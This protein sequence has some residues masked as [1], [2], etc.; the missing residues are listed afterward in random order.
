M[1]VL[2]MRTVVFLCVIS[3][4]ICTVFIARL[5][6][7]NRSRFE[8][9]GYWAANCVMQTVGLGL[10]TARGALPDWV[11]IVLANTLVLAGAVLAYN[12]LERFFRK[13]GP[14]WHNYLLLALGSAALAYF[15]L[16]RA[17]LSSRVLVMSVILL[18]FF[19][20]CLWLLRFRADPVLRPLA[21]G[22][23]AV[24][25]G[26]CLVSIVRIVDYVFGPALTGDFFEPNILQALVMVTYQILFI[27]LTYSLVVM[28]NQRLV[29]EIATEQAKFSSAF[30][31]APYA[32]TLTRLADGV[33]IDTNRQFEEITGY[34]RAD[35]IGQSTITLH[36]WEREEDRA[37]VAQA[38]AE[39][40][41]VVARE[42]NFRTK[43]GERVVGLL[44]AEIVIVDGAD[45]V[46]SCI[47]DITVRKHEEVVLHEREAQLETQMAAA[48]A[49][50]R[51]GRIAA[52]NL[53]EDA[54]TAKNQA[55]SAMARAQAGEQR[56][57]LALRAAN[58]GV[59]DLNVQ[60][61]EAVVSAE[62]ALMLGYDPATFHE[63]NAAWLA[64]LHP[65]DFEQAAKAY[66]D[67]LAGITSEYRVEF[68]QKTQAGDWKWI[69]SLGRLVEYDST[70]QPL[71]M[72]G[73]HTD[74]TERKRN[75]ADLQLQARRSDAL[76][77]LP[78]RAETMDESTFMQ[79]G[80]E[81]A[82][83]LTGSTV[84]FIH[85]VNEDQET[86]EL[87]NWSRGT[88]AHY[89]KAAFDSH[90]PVSEAG[91]WADALRQRQPVVYNSYATATG[92]HG[93]PEGHAH[94]ERLVSV[95]VMDG[96]QVRMMSGVGNKPEPYTE[97]DV[98][99]VRLV[100]ETMWRLVQRQRAKAALLASEQRSKAVLSALFEGVVLQQADGK[101]T[102]WNPAVERI[103][104]LTGE[105]LLGS[106]TFDPSWRTIYE[107]GSH[108]PRARFPAAET[109]R[110]G[111]PQSNVVMGVQKSPTDLTWLSISSVPI[112]GPA[113]T[114]PTAVVVSLTDITDRK[115]AD[116]RLAEQL[117]ELRR[118]Q[119]VT[120]GR[121]GRVLA[122]KQ[123][124][125]SL[126]AAHGQPPRYSSAVD[127][128][129]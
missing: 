96:G 36:I 15:S 76:L 106:Q 8:G 25:A 71:R 9:L 78:L 109:L 7:Q 122:I 2:D 120:L 56:L 24:F 89:C 33:I 30:H 126:L 4:L 61:G 41:R 77:D 11:S 16:I 42:V 90:Y 115:R 128:G 119:Q 59:Y 1:M 93:L 74:I 94:L 12:G 66:R 84:A 95:P 62:Y 116:G 21:W 111:L 27:A 34:S 123:E 40:G 70:G 58:Q 51:T 47:L 20:Q 101:I 65:A 23:G 112:F 67:Y 129:D 68:R 57:E 22:V 91:I 44:S 87:V 46:L 17:D 18:V 108:F 63:T 13:P 52:L 104:G 55:I 103:L 43:S 29:M 80:Q 92:K 53:M 75:E 60:T 110:T 85:F 6:R 10:I 39:K 113:G 127:A 19:W 79:Y 64:R 32:I 49:A 118:W 54:T 69:L 100:A 83:A 99:T 28:V 37:V 86:I 38:L 88:L 5:W 14:Q 98:E 125:N 105:Q 82:E 121:E 81:V 117:A 3:Y 50:Q 31:L 45:D 72:L 26:Y 97:R 73:A 102:A 48:L 124:V 107:D 35:V 114:L